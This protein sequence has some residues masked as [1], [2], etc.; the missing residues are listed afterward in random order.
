MTFESHFGYTCTMFFYDLLVETLNRGPI[1]VCPCCWWDIQPE[2]T[3]SFTSDGLL[4][5]R[6][7][8]AN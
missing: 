4:S 5:S 6:K 7:N 1:S 3:D 2:F 8:P